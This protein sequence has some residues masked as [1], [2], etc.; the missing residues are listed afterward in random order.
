MRAKALLEAGGLASDVV[1]V[2]TARLDPLAGHQRLTPTNP[3]F[4]VSAVRA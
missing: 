4:L 3:V 1:L 2:Q